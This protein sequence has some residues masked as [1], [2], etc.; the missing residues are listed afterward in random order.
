MILKTVGKR[1]QGMDDNGDEMQEEGDQQW[2]PAVRVSQAQQWPRVHRS[3]PFSS[4]AYDLFHA[5][6]LRNNQLDASN[7]VDN[8]ELDPNRTLDDEQQVGV[9]YDE[10]N[11][12]NNHK[13]SGLNI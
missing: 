6:D 10:D 5:M 1:A 8:F 4:S 13:S 11:N 2:Q 12:N 3:R 7:A 9:E